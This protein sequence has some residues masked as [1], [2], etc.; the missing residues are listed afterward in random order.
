MSEIVSWTP[1]A[2]TLTRASPTSPLPS[3]LVWGSYAAAA[4]RQEA[5][6]RSTIDEEACLPRRAGF[7]SRRASV[8]IDLRGYTT[9]NESRALAIAHV[10]ASRTGGPF[11]T[12]TAQS[13]AAPAL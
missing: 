11:A 12:R 5:V 8:V 3:P 6:S 4:F 9:V 7:A 10:P 1:I 2:S 13:V